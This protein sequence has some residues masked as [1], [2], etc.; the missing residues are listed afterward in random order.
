M[1]QRFNRPSAASSLVLLAA[2]ALAGF[3]SSC[4]K[5]R[6]EAVLNRLIDAD[7]E[8]VA[9]LDPRSDFTLEPAWKAPI[10]GQAGLTAWSFYVPDAPAT[11]ARGGGIDLAPLGRSK[12]L[13]WSGSLKAGAFDALRLRFRAPLSGQVELYWNGAG[14]DFAP[15]RYLLH[16]PDAS[17]PRRVTF[18]LGTARGWSGNVTRIGFRLLGEPPKRQALARAEGLRYVPAP[19]VGRGEARFVALDGRGLP[20]WLARPGLTLLRR[21][22]VPPGA[23]LRLQAAPWLPAGASV[24]IRVLARGTQGARV[25]RV[26]VDQKLRPSEET[27]LRQW[28][29]LV[30]DLAPLAGETVDLLFETG[31]APPGSLV[32]WGN[33]RIVGPARERRPNVLLISLDTV[34]ADHLSLYDYRRPTTPNLEKWAKRWATVFETT[35][36]SAPWTLPSHVSMLSGLDAVRHGVNRH[37]PIPSEIT[38]LPQRFRDA[39]YL[40]YA[41]TAG[42]LL[43]PEMGFARGFDELDVRGRMESLPD[44]D[45]DLA[46]GV[47][48]ALE[49]LGRHRGQRF[50][51][52]F[53]TFEAH[54]PYQA[55]EPYFSR[56]GGVPGALNAGEPVWLEENGVEDRVRPRYSLFLPPTHAA[57]VEYPKRVLERRDRALAQA[58]YD[59]GLAYIDEQLGR[60]FEY[61]ESE[62]L[63]E[64]TIVV[65]TSDH[66]EAL[67]EHGLVGHASLYDH[68]LLVPLVIAAPI[69][70]GRGRR[71]AG[72]VRLVDIAP[73]LLQLAGLPSLGAI[74]GRSLIRLLYGLASPPRDAWS[75]ALS[76]ARGVS[77]RSAVAPRK[78]IAQDT[79][80]DPFRGGLE[81]YDLKRDPGEERNLAPTAPAA[82]ETLRRR[83][84][85]QVRTDQAAL[86]IQ[87]AN[88]SR[89]AISGLLAGSV[90][91][92]MITST[93]LGFSCCA[94]A[95]DG[96]RFHAPP[97]AR[98]TLTLPGRRAAG[99]LKLLLSAQ[100]SS[101]R[102]TLPIDGNPLHRRIVWENGRWREAPAELR[103]APH[104]T[105]TGVEIRHQGSF[106]GA[107]QE[108]EELRDRLRA[109]GYIR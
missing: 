32:L 75:Y 68:D 9:G 1:A 56:F 11:L 14:E 34:R 46:T 4:R 48:D 7:R 15:Q 41:T 64:N 94:S 5:D 77:L 55:R 26:L 59:S 29:R 18:D 23:H 50:F 57:G 92:A 106:G 90:V 19:G 76:T 25:Q 107:K 33:P 40:T 35:V 109:L 45:A 101:W 82:G 80:F 3:A 60:L 24:R 17:D 28:S 100:G 31:P 37:G 67:F 8:A 52:F 66:G 104:G 65:I 93:D 47:D 87:V 89:N 22:M 79:I 83:L 99:T 27:P 62:D 20:A 97:G 85:S 58:L 12:Y 73:T 95:P 49:W 91:D 38:L 84:L 63:L 61:L 51:L 98:Y 2:L 71:V 39:G 108:D 53:H 81:I 96:V 30:A 36:A 103:N 70:E 102:G 72:Q 88:A 6:G 13:V 16:S 74:D 21:V 42:V 54:T 43:T 78:A 44:W 69:D 105:W 86:Q 10:D